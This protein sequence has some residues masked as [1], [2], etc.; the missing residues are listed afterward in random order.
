MA[1]FINVLKESLLGHE[2]NLP[3]CS[4]K[5]VEPLHV[6][7]TYFENRP[8]PHSLVFRK[9]EYQVFEIFLPR[10]GK[11]M[12]Q[13]IANA[14]FEANRETEGNNVFGF[15]V[16][17]MLL[18]VAGKVVSGRTLLTCREGDLGLGS[19]PEVTT[20]YRLAC[21]RRGTNESAVIVS[22]VDRTLSAGCS[23]RTNSDLSFLKLTPSE[24]KDL[25]QHLQAFL[26]SK[27]FGDVRKG[28]TTPAEHR[29]QAL[30]ADAKDAPLAGFTDRS[31][32]MTARQLIDGRIKGLRYLPGLSI[33]VAVIITLVS[34]IIREWWLFILF[35]PYSVIYCWL[36]AIVK[37]RMACPNCG[38][39]LRSFSEEGGLTFTIDRDVKCCPY[40]GYNLDAEVEDDAKAKGG[41]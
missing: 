2:V 17:F 29:E 24:L 27:E 40:C 14:Q 4:F 28:N 12:E 10:Y 39:S 15:W 8:F 34:M 1:G 19:G 5:R 41:G 22:S 37:K 20:R 9:G 26:Q 32:K 25:I 13:F 7:Y 31:E 35:M 30:R 38:R 16:R 23:D 33:G 36:F 11:D 21:C 18:L 6:F 3:V